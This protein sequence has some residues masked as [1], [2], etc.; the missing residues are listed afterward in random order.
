MAGAGYY[1][2][3]LLASG[4]VTL[5]VA[6]LFGAALGLGRRVRFDAPMHRRRT[7][8]ASTT[9]TVAALRRAGACTKPEMGMQ[10]SVRSWTG[11]SPAVGRDAAG[12]ESQ[13]ARWNMATDSA[14]GRSTAADVV[15]A[16][17]QLGRELEDADP[18][19][20]AMRT[21]LPEWLR[22]TA[23]RGWSFRWR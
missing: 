23:M 17:Q 1:V 15:S 2:A 18:R 8:I 3:T 5:Q 20:C 12:K 9:A 11:E 10:T 6:L 16:R 4:G 14:A 21:E 13:A 22:R 7:A 19:R